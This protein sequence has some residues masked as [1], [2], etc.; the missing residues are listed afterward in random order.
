MLPANLPLISKA[1]QKPYR[2]VNNSSFS[3]SAQD[4]LSTFRTQGENNDSPIEM[5]LSSN[6]SL[7]QGRGRTSI[8]PTCNL[9]SETPLPVSKSCSEL[10]NLVGMVRDLDMSHVEKGDKLHPTDNLSPEGSNASSMNE[11]NT[12]PDRIASASIPV[13]N[14]AKKMY[15]DKFLSGYKRFHSVFNG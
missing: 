1:T 6:T 10:T 7:D 3:P 4:F 12:S 15:I 2:G 13:R 14:M 9:P 11:A 5:Y 8:A